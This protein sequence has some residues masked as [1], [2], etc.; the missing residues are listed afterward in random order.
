MSILYNGVGSKDT[1]A[2]FPE[3]NFLAN[4][5]AITPFA[6]AIQCMRIE[7]VYECNKGSIYYTDRHA[8]SNIAGI[9]DFVQQQINFTKEATSGLY[10]ASAYIAYKMAEESLILLPA[11]VLTSGIIY[12]ITELR[13]GIELLIFN[14]IL[15]MILGTSFALMLSGI[16]SP[17]VRSSLIV[18]FNTIFFLMNGI[19]VRVSTMP[20]Y[21]RW[22]VY[23]H[24]RSSW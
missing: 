18:A 23:A 1:L 11:G 22:Y 19:A 7:N 5:L 4:A 9:G 17:Y 16:G 20:V 6:S 13:F 14:T 3:N 12:P 24:Q 15:Q 10:S 21:V 8:S 2:Y